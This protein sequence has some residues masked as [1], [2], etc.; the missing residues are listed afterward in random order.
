LSDQVS[1][2]FNT[3]FAGGGGAGIT[4]INGD[5]TPAQNIIAST[6]I[7]VG[8]AGANHSIGNTGVLS[9]AKQG[10]PPR[11]GNIVLKPSATVTITEAPNG[12][13]EFDAVG[14]AGIVS[15]N[16]DLTAAQILAA[17]AGISIVA[18][19]A[20]TH[21]I[22]VTGG[23]GIVSINGDV[24]AAQTLAG[25]LGID[26]VDL[27]GGGHN[28]LPP[29]R[30]NFFASAGGGI[31]VPN[32][33]GLHVLATSTIG[34]GAGG[35]YYI[36]WG[37]GVNGIAA[38]LLD[39]GFRVNGVFTPFG[40]VS[41]MPEFAGQTCILTGSSVGLVLLA[42]GDVVD[43]VVDHHGGGAATTSTAASIA[44]FKVTT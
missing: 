13:Y 17:G 30:R 44:G 26:V 12:T 28:I 20:G 3:Q 9:V 18:G 25:A 15:I 33:G 39:A 41:G 10:S 11:T 14:A 34:A 1:Q 24:T 4:T 43:V 16:G 42:P 27:G 23:A 5:A 6:G 35:Q 38:Q 2:E 37:A 29:G 19:P 21:T 7:V 32:G 22:A 36:S 40:N 31:A 8:N